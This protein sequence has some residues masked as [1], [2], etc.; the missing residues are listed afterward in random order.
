M[1]DKLKWI[2]GGIALILVAVFVV[3][4]LFEGYTILILGVIPVSP[5]VISWV[6]GIFG[7]LMVVLGFLNEEKKD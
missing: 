5:T 4:A 7:A 6:F 1:N 2:L 3:P